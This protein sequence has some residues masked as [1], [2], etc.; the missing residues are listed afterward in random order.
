MRAKGPANDCPSLDEVALI[1]GG[2][3]NS[4]AQDIIESGARCMQGNNEVF[5]RLAG[6]RRVVSDSC[7]ASI[8]IERAG[9]GQKDEAR[10]SGSCCRVGVLSHIG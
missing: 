3:E 7:G 8:E 1:R 4:C 6:L 9:A 10:L 2:D 5:H